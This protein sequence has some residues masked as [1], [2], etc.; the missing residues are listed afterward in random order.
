MPPHATWFAGREPVLGFLAGHVLREPGRFTARTAPRLANGRPTLAVYTGDRVPHALQV[1]G[2]ATGWPPGSRAVVFGSAAELR[3]SPLSGS[4]AGAKATV[5]LTT[6]YA[7]TQGPAATTLLPGMTPG[8]TVGETGIEAYAASSGRTADELRA[9][10]AGA[11]GPAAIGA[12]VVTLV[13]VPVADLAAA[14]RLDGDRLVSIP[15]E[16][17]RP[18]AR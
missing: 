6:A 10:P 5:R 7:A 14:Y 17:G 3:G 2:P 9:G 16:P 15:T 4:Y 18:P 8:T 13:T 1:L 12:A 11:P